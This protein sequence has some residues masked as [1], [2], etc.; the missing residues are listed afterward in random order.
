MKAT[1]ELASKTWN[2]E[3]KWD[4]YYIEW[5]TVENFIKQCEKVGDW[6]T[7]CAAAQLWMMI[8]KND[9]SKLKINHED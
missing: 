6:K 7:I 5:T 9:F 4:V 1:I 8:A 3:R 2:V